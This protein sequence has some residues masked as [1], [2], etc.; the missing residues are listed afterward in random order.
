MAKEKTIKK[1]ISDMSSWVKAKD[2]YEDT[3]FESM[4]RGRALFNARILAERIDEVSFDQ[5][6]T[7]ARLCYTA[8]GWYVSTR[9]YYDEW[10]GILEQFALKAGMLEPEDFEPKTVKKKKVA[11]D[12][13]F[14]G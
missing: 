6:E 10:C 13:N 12:T 5:A 11:Y 3:S 4:M 7:V 2:R 8:V 9:G 1:L 14:Y